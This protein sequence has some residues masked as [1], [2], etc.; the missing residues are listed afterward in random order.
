[1]LYG[2]QHNINVLQQTNNSTLQK[3]SENA[4]KEKKMIKYH[5][6]VESI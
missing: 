2:L 5:I 3:V 6:Y 4:S 1:V